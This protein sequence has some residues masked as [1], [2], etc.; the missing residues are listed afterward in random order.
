MGLLHVTGKLK[1]R[2]TLCKS[3]KKIERITIKTILFLFWGF[4]F[5]LLHLY[6][7]SSRYGRFC[8]GG[9][10]SNCFPGRGSSHPCTA[11]TQLPEAPDHLVQRWAEDSLKQPHVSLLS[12]QLGFFLGLSEGLVSL[13]CA[14]AC[15]SECIHI[16]VALNCWRIF[17]LL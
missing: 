16:G 14:C 17:F 13:T 15:L 12:P 10:I 2:C 11:N 4:A 9:E 1:K 8:G 7:M 6:F 3:V 5:L